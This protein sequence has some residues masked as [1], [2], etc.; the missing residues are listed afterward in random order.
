M[1]VDVGVSTVVGGGACGVVSVVLVVSEVVAMMV[2]VIAVVKVVVIVVCGVDVCSGTV[3]AFDITPLCFY[4]TISSNIRAL[5]PLP[6]ETRVP[7]ATTI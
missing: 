3:G 2:V 5:I 6:K 4:P 7:S 1:L